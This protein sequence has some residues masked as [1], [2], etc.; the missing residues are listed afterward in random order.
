MIR[1]ALIDALLS[2]TDIRAASPYEDRAETIS[3]M[4]YAS[5]WRDRTAP[6]ADD[7]PELGHYDLIA[8]WTL[9]I[10]IRE[11]STVESQATADAVTE[12]L[13]DVFKDFGD[14]TVPSSEFRVDMVIVN[15]ASVED[16]GGSP[17]ILVVQASLSTALVT[18]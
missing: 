8:E 17:P 7:Q 18:T 5:L 11:E 3:D 14:L 10:Y 2:V 4:P 16:R 12:S 1:E 6:P 15:E 13:F 9:N